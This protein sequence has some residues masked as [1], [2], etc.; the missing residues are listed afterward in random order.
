MEKF[1]GN[2]VKTILGH[3]NC[4]C[5][6]FNVE[7]VNN[8]IIFEKKCSGPQFR[9]GFYMPIDSWVVLGLTYDGK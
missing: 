1:E 4:G 2:E 9:T 8:E 7:N 5:Y 6:D 3:S